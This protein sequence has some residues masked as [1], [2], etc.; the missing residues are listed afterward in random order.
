[1]IRLLALALGVLGM[2]IIVV[3][4]LRS[5]DRNEPDQIVVPAA[6]HGPATSSA[7]S[8]MATDVVHNA[9]IGARISALSLQVEQLRREVSALRASA[10]E[11]AAWSVRRADVPI[12]LQG[13]PPPEDPEQASHSD[14]L[15]ITDTALSLD[16]ALASEDEDPAVRDRVAQAAADHFAARGSADN[17]TASITCAHDMCRLVVRHGDEHEAEALMDAVGSG[18]FSAGSFM[19]QAANGEETVIYAA[20]P[21][22]EDEFQ[23]RLAAAGHARQ[24]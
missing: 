6:A 1:M 18:P 14:Y 2:A 16:D 19:Y 8:R 12:A 10:H 11:R 9:G 13:A 22:Y 3:G 4:L 21:G 7:E 17:P 5:E 24:P 23:Q 20:L 15:T